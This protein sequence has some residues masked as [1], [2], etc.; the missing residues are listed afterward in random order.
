MELT[1]GRGAILEECPVM[2]CPN[3]HSPNHGS[4]P[5]ETLFCAPSTSAAPLL[6]TTSVSGDTP[7]S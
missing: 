6:P 5:A 2:L 7:F 1:T 3:Y 4:V